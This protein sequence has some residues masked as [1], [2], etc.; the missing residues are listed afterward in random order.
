MLD[1]NGNGQIDPVDVA[2]HMAMDESA[3]EGEPKPEPRR[4]ATGGGCLTACLT[5]CLM[6]AVGALAL[7]LF[8]L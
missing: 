8:M 4:K 5:A 7:A 1:W 2:I 3:V 6:G